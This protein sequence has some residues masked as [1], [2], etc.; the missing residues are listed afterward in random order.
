V[1]TV[2]ADVRDSD[3]EH[4][5]R[6]FAREVAACRGRPLRTKDNHFVAIFDGPGRA[7]RCGCSVKTVASRSRIDVSA[8]VH[9]G[10]CEPSAASGPLILISAEIAAA[11]SPG[12]VL[13]SRT[14][15]DLVPGSG[16]QFVD[17]GALRVAELN[18]DLS[19]LAVA[20][21]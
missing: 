8:G 19:V 17:R 6:V 7:V 21:R 15:V 18:R 14:V 9:I 1:L 4:L 3:R 11:A 5:Q 10:E 13:V 20:T 12:E 16:L 2:R